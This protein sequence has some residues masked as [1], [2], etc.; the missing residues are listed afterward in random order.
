MY[1]IGIGIRVGQTPTGNSATL[2]A[3]IAEMLITG[4]DGVVTTTRAGVEPNPL[5]GA[6]A[7]AN[8]PVTRILKIGN[9]SIPGAVFLAQGTR[10]NLM[11]V[12]T[13]GSNGLSSNTA[14]PGSR[15][16]ERTLVENTGNSDHRAGYLSISVS[17]AT[18]YC[19]SF[20][21][22]RGV[23]NRNVY[24]QLYDGVANG[25]S[26]TFNLDTFAVITNVAFGGGAF[27]RASVTALPG[28][29]ALCQI[30]GNSSTWNA[31]LANALILFCAG[32]TQSY[33]GDGTSS[34]IISGYQVEQAEY[35]SGPIVWDGGAGSVRNASLHSWNQS[36]ATPAGTMISIAQ[37]YGWS[38]AYYDAATRRLYDGVN[39][40]TGRTGG[41]WFAQRVDNVAANLN[42]T[43]ANAVPVSLATSIIAQRWDAASNRITAG[44]VTVSSAAPS[45]PFAAATPLIIGNRAALDL[46][47]DGWV[48]N[49]LF[50]RALTDAEVALIAASSIII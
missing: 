28:G 33:T 13:G 35:A 20:Q 10:T 29:W 41:S 48:A 12:M 25:F 7:T 24:V 47:G 2:N 31:S 16:S 26:A 39:G 11:G 44:G 36:L 34:L 30:T 19:V 23:G 21:V 50:P 27:V 8:N 22:K 14:A 40:I 4:R 17:A 38:Q 1:P 45:L 46:P 42:V 5:G 32:S 37:P 9:T 43:S 18:N 6:D 49:L 15:P 3:L